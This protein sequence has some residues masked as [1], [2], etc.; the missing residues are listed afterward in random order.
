VDLKPLSAH[1]LSAG[2]G[3]AFPL[4][5][6]RSPRPTAPGPPFQPFPGRRRGRLVRVPGRRR[7]AR[8]E[9]PPGDAPVAANEPDR[10]AR[11][12]AAESVRRR[13]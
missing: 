4:L 10:E 6:T 12:G 9:P 7:P 11:K 8:C 1:G 2:S 3:R 5:P 13:R